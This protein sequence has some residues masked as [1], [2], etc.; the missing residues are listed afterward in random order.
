MLPL[1][2]YVR[3][4]KVG[5][6]EGDG[7]ISPDEQERAIREWSERSGTPVVIQA[8]ELDV[9]GGT[10]DRP[11]FNLCMDRVRRQESGGIVV[12]KT[13]RFARS[14]QGAVSTLAEIGKHGGAFASA[15]EPNLDYSTPSGKAF[16]HMLFVFAE[17]TR[18]SLKESWA[19]TQRNAILERNIHISPNGY[20]GYDRGE[21]KRLVPNADAPT[22]VEVFE[23]RAAGDTW[24]SLA[25]WL[26]G[27]AARADGKVWTDQAVQRLCAKRVYRGEAS[28]YVDQDVDGRGAIVNPDAHPALVTEAQ[29]QAAQ[30][31]QPR[32]GGQGNGETGLL[33]GLVRCGGCRHMMSAGRDHNGGRTYGCRGKK[34]TGRCGEPATIMADRLEQHVEGLVLAEIDAAVKIVPSSGD[35]AA[36]VEQLALARTDLA[37][38]RADTAARRKLG[39]EQ[40]HEWLDGYMQAVR[41]SKGELERLNAQE[42]VS[43]IGIARDHYLSLPTDDRRQVLAGF[44]DA[45]MVRRSKGRGRNSDPVDRRVQVLWRGQAP[46]D[47]PRRRVASPIVPFDFDADDVVAGA[48]SG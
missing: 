45:V 10:M 18:D 3:V 46:A 16:L 4:S 37:E 31:A 30:T 26:D 27:T 34:S 35:R 17:F 41:R 13:D 25:D 19:A 47:L 6:R 1:D 32:V 11:V 48:A 39:S 33:A 42:G 7:F 20:L 22:V 24:G 9:S 38:F 40:W 15:T 28:R 8:H 2:G 12:F 14:L 36:A 43:T 29:W 5:G 44:V 21:D 23:R